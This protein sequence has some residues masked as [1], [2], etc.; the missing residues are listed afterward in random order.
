M[1]VKR[2]WNQGIVT[3]ALTATLDHLF[4][5]RSENEPKTDDERDEDPEHV[6]LSPN[7]M[8]RVWLYPSITAC[9]DPENA[10]SIRVLEKHHFEKGALVE[11]AFQRGDEWRD[12][13]F[14]RLEREKWL[15]ERK[16]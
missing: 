7:E 9:V 4:S 11:K 2:H 13:L 14:F 12:E 6:S 8:R 15:K 1:L 16:R 5:L 3:E 10:A